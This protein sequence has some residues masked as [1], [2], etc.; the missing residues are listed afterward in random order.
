MRM[1]ASGITVAVPFGEPFHND[2]LGD[3]TGRTTK[4]DMSLC[5]YLY[6]GSAW[7]GSATRLWNALPEATKGFPALD[8]L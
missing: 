5:C 2:L 1:L 7:I 8:K 4:T 3:L 6:V